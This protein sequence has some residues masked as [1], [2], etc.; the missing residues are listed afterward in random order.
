[1]SRSLCHRIFRYTKNRGMAAVARQARA[2]SMLGDRRVNPRMRGVILPATSANSL[3]KN[4]TC[5]T[6]SVAGEPGLLQS[7]HRKLCFSETI[8]RLCSGVVCWSRLGHMES[9]M[10]ARSGGLAGPSGSR[11]RPGNRCDTELLGGAPSRVGQ[12]LSLCPTCCLLEHR[13]TMISLRDPKWAF[14]L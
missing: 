9:E 3:E 14:A 12:P 4:S 7:I 13:A 2:S 6:R 8:Y 11:E 10:V 1:M 5:R